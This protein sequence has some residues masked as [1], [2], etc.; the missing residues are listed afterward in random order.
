MGF[1]P[2][3][4]LTTDGKHTILEGRRFVIVN[5]DYRESYVKENKI[6]ASIGPILTSRKPLK[7]QMFQYSILST[8]VCRVKRIHLTSFFFL[9]KTYLKTY[10][11]SLRRDIAFWKLRGTETIN[12]PVMLFSVLLMCQIYGCS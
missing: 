3:S 5:S 7:G 8:N 12:G 4:C 6:V 2:T 1:N 10:T 11:G 9:K